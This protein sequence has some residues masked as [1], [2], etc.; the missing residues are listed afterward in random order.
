MSKNCE[1]QQNIAIVWG[2]KCVNA[3]GLIRSL[4]ERGYYV[5]FASTYSKIESKYTKGYLRLPKSDEAQIETMLDYLRTLPS[6]PA[7][8]TVDDHCN[9]L[10]DEHYQTLEKYAFIPHAKGRLKEISDKSVMS[11]IAQNSGLNVPAFEKLNLT[12]EIAW[13]LQ[14]P[15]ILKP[16]AGYAGSKGDIRIC[17]TKEDAAV[18]MQ[19]LREKGYQEVLVQELLCDEDQFEIGLMGIA[20]PNGEVEIPC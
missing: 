18:W 5:L 14:F 16:Y 2:P 11:Q 8:F 3:T 4:G 9:Y 10:L 17:T 19:T 7:I 13:S 15:V 12:G 1:N 6:K 20:L